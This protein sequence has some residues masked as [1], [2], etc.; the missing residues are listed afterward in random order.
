MPR[1]FAEHGFSADMCLPHDK[2]RLFCD[3]KDVSFTASKME[4]VVSLAEAELSADIPLCPVSL[5]R[6]FVTD[7]NRTGYEA[8]YF[9]RRDMALR[10]AL[11]EAYEKKGRFTEKLADVV[12]AI[13]EESTWIVPAHLNMYSP[14]HGDI[15]LPPVYNG[16]RLHDIDLFSAATSALLSLIYLLDREALDAYSPLICEKLVYTVKERLIK[17]FVN[18]VLHWMGLLGNAVNNWNPW[19]ISNVLFTAAVIE[20]DDRTL[21]LVVGTAAQCIDNYTKYVPADGGCDEGPNY[22]TVA[23]AS[24]FDS[25]ELF[26]DLTG[27]NF[28]IFDDPFVKAMCEYEP[29]MYIHGNRFINY[30]DCPPTVNADG[31]L[32]SRMGRKCGSDLLVRFGDGIAGFNDVIL[33]T[34]NVYRTLRCLITPEHAGKSTGQLRSWLP[35]LKIMTARESERTD[36]GMFVS[37]KGGHN[38][39]GHN[40]IDVGNMI[41]YCDGEPVLIDTGAGA[42]KRQTFSSR[43]YELWYMQSGYHNTADVGG[44]GQ[45]PGGR[46]RSC[47]EVYDEKTGGLE[48]ELKNAY[49]QEAGI[50]SY[51]RSVVLDGSVVRVKDVFRLD[52]EKEVDIHFMSCVKPEALNGAVR[53]ARGCVMRYDPRLAAG[54]EEFPVDDEALEERWGSPVL[55]RIHFRA[56][57]TEAS[58]AFEIEKET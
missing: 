19:V 50:I 22:W 26:Y 29:K 13:M 3:E 44:Y 51:K 17:P 56:A 30:A 54:I 8:V 5:Y 16:D 53:L 57:A 42:Y 23:G 24:Y 33:S 47:D 36:R 43:R 7:G 21:K 9:R 34:G 4:K 40:H 48:M 27:G 2:V 58:F 11:A 31:S 45:L 38:A 55:W 41:V 25:L 18:C 14:S 37:A 39:E 20:D 28:D 49:P 10:L 32:L 6:R 52:G 15:G 46:Y 35:E 12:W 1:L